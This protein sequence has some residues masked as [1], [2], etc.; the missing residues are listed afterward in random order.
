MTGMTQR[1]P[2]LNEV[3]LLV[4]RSMLNYPSI[5][6]SRFAALQQI[7]LTNGNGMEWD[8]GR[9]VYSR[10]SES[11]SVTML[12]DDIN[13]QIKENEAELASCKVDS[14]RGLFLQRRVQ[15]EREL[16][17]RQHIERHIDV[18]A[19]G[20]VMGEDTQYNA[21]WLRNI[22]PD[23]TPLSI[24][25]EYAASFPEEMLP[26][27]AQ[28]AEEIVRIAKDSLWRDMGM[29]S[30][31]FDSA[32]AD[33]KKLRKYEKFCEILD[34]LD[35]FTGWKEREVHMNELMSEIANS[36]EAGDRP[37]G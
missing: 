23:W 8:G 21:E 12:Y 14:L 19:K 37:R 30:E 4:K 20:H 7:F 5:T 28:A 32:K 16:M 13:E 18:Y 10:G 33:P 15:Y 25:N 35:K 3:D 9:L 34:A 11:E 27:W 2:A 1:T 17:N 26:D 29:Y 36:V 22:D 6:P 31:R 24:N